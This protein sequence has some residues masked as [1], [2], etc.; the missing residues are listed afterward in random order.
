[1]SATALKNKIN[2]SLEEMDAS[3]LQSAYL[4][5][6][7]FLNQQKYAGTKVDKKALDIKIAKG[8][9]ELDNGKGTDFRLFLN[10]TQAS[11]GKRK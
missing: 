9:K 3:Q 2:K 4:I 11:Y 7:E 10:D 1:M 8:I 5:L 6:K